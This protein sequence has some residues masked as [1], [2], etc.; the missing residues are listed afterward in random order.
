VSA[1]NYSRVRPR[2]RLAVAAAVLLACAAP[3]SQALGAQ[4][5]RNAAS[6]QAADVYD[7]IERA[8]KA[9]GTEQYAE[10]GKA[11][12]SVLQMPAFAELPGSDQFRAFMIAAFA[13]EGREDYLGAH[14]FLSIATEFPD[15]TANT[16]RMRVGLA[17]LVDDWIDAG[18]SLT[19]LAKRWPDALAKLD[20]RTI[21]RI[22]AK[23]ADNPKLAADRQ[24]LL[25]ALFAARF[26]Y[27]WDTQPSTLWRDLALE[28]L[29]RKDLARAREI[30]QRITGAPTLI[31]MRVDRRYDELVHADPK[32]FDVAAAANTECKRLRRVVEDHPRSLEPLVQYLYA[33]FIVGGHK[34]VLS[35]TDKVLARN[36][37]ATVDKPA[38]DD[39][40]D[41]LNWIY[42]LRAYA[43][44]RMGR[45]DEGL[46]SQK[47]ARE[48]RESS[49]DK[50][51]QAINL[52][53]TYTEFAR[54]DD[55]LKSLEG[56]DWANSLSG[57]GRMQLQQA[58]LRAYLQ[59]GKRGEAQEIFAYLREHRADAPD[60]WLD[61]LLDW[62]EVDEAAAQYIEN[63]RDTQKRA[64][65]L[66]K[67]QIFREIPRLPQAA[68]EHT[69]WQALLARPDVTAAINE[70]GRREKQP[71]YFF[72]E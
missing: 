69:R 45:W 28:A 44:M 11:I 12:D 32:M 48:Q 60:S 35:Q 17:T 3:G 57:Y 29:Q 40:A 51:S 62:G 53:F 58:R 36:A 42:D 71:V 4:K 20:D 72:D 49:S 61:T 2:S 13:A 31:S 16:W 33:L 9:L 10:A 47:A 15:A 50:V 30:Q 66:Y 38:F 52:A 64:D 37:A 7:I 22:A 46:S 54:P 6:V 23:M 14:E 5:D 65:A 43:L 41:Q 63:L 18:S 21:A 56:I 27:R 34:E 68:A 25:K 1:T 26:T 19:T 55:A 70:V 8:R 24:E 59:L 67:A 39:V